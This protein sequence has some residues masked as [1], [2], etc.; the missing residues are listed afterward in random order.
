MHVSRT[1]KVSSGARTDPLTRLQSAHKKVSDWSAARQT[2]R[3]L[4]AS[5]GQRFLPALTNTARTADCLRTCSRP[6][7]GFTRP[8]TRSCCKN[9]RS[10][11]SWRSIFHPEALTSLPG[12][13]PSSWRTALSTKTSG[14]FLPRQAKSSSLSL[15]SRRTGG[16]CNT[17]FL[18][19]MLSDLFRRKSKSSVLQSGRRGLWT[20]SK[21]R[22]PPASR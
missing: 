12:S 9:S 7:Y 1:T 20:S 6:A 10:Q 2:T 17:R 15:R 16:T 18:S 8:K 5:R 13:A 3:P 19:L 14:C 11:T 22:G 4:K 21:S